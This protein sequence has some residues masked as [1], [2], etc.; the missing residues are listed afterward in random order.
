MSWTTVVTASLRWVWARWRWL[1]GLAVTLVLVAGPT[2]PGRAN[3]DTDAMVRNMDAGAYTDW[4]SPLLMMAWRPFYEVGIDIGFIQIGQISVFFVAVGVLVRPLCT[5]QWPAIALT[6]ALCV[7]PP[8]YAMLTNV[9]R[10]TWF[11]TAVVASLA[12]VFR[13]R[14]PTALHGALLALSFLAIVASRQ[15]GLVT[16]MVLAFVAAAHWRLLTTTRSA[17]ARTVTWGAL[18]VAVCIGLFGVTQITNRLADVTPTGP[19]TATFYVDLDDMS[20]RVGRVLIP[21]VYVRDTLTLDELAE[22]RNYSAD[23]VKSRVF[24]RLPPDDRP[25]ATTAW[26]EAVLE[27]PYVYLQSRWQMFT[28][29]IGWSGSPLEAHYPTEGTSALYHPWSARLSALSTSYLEMFDGGDWQRGGV[30]HRPWLYLVIAAAA[31]G[32]YGRRWPLLY[33]IPA[34]QLS[35][36]A[37][38]FFLSPISKARL[39]YPCFVLGSVAA[40]YLILGGRA[41]LLEQLQSRR[42]AETPPTTE[43][44]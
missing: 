28:R 15:N 30:L 3:H 43:R 32:W 44:P 34:V 22:E 13:L 2:F 23:S 11:T 41:L 1:G 19:E 16:V 21:S 18:S 8:T 14:R 38:L 6:L 5:K 17:I 27:Y 10:D 39:V 25:A 9:I 35:V 40:A 37:S 24:L 31:A 42:S 12:I 20:T 36:L 7:F 4:W 29:Q 33:A 26:R